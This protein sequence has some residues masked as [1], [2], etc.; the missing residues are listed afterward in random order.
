MTQN[1]YISKWSLEARFRRSRPTS[2]TIRIRHGLPNIRN[3]RVVTRRLLRTRPRRH[4]ILARPPRTIPRAPMK[5]HLPRLP[6]RALR[7][8]GRSASARAEVPA[9]LRP[10]PRRRALPHQLPVPIL[11]FP[12]LASQ[13]PLAFER[14]VE[15]RSDAGELGL[16][17]T[18]R[19]IGSL[20][21]VDGPL[22][23]PA[24]SV[25]GVVDGGGGGDDPRGRRR[26]SIGR[27][28]RRHGSKGGHGS[29]HGI[30]DSRIG[31]RGRKGGHRSH[32]DGSLR[33][34]PR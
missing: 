1:I 29:S 9:E 6:R 7:T 11:R 23:L 18:A 28:R 8:L 34:S 5:I 27:R 14:V 2:G 22:E 30:R 3:I 12:R 13:R 25:A 24:P 31:P 20:E 4:R 17:A 33:S 10:R 21:G 16:D 15:P 32:H 26:R 19:A